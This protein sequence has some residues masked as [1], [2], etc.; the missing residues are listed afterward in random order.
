[1]NTTTKNTKILKLNSATYEITPNVGSIVS[2]G[3]RHEKLLPCVDEPCAGW[4]GAGF[5]YPNPIREW[6]ESH[7]IACNVTVS[8]RKIHTPFDGVNWVT[9]RIEW[10]GDCEPSTFTSGK[11]L[12]NAENHHEIFPE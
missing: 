7:A 12:L 11:M 6:A 8:G 10:V 4:P 9:V 1:M 2:L 5:R 3:T